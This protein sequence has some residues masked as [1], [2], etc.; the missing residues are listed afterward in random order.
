MGKSFLTRCFVYKVYCKLMYRHTEQ[1]VH[2][3]T[4]RA[5]ARQ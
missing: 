4:M 3:D 1:G 5:P 2:K